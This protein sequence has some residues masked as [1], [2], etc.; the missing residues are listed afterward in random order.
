MRVIENMQFA[1]GKS[2]I[3]AAAVVAALVIGPGPSQGAP[4]VVVETEGPAWRP[5]IPT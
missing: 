3:Y 2:I 4:A 1:P 5:A